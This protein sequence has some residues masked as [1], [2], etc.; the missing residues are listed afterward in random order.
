MNRID[1]IG[2]VTVAVLALALGLAPASLAARDRSSEQTIQDSLGTGIPACNAAGQPSSSAS[3]I[4]GA[5]TYDSR[6]LPWIGQTI[7]MSVVI[8]TTN[9][10]CLQD[11]EGTTVATAQRFGVE[12]VLPRGAKLRT[13]TDTA[14]TCR[15]GPRSTLCPQAVSVR[16]G[17]RG[18]VQLA[19]DGAAD[20]RFLIGP[21]TQVRL[22]FRVRLTRAFNGVGKRPPRCGRR[23]APCSR[24]ALKNF[25]AIVVDNDERAAEPAAHSTVSPLLPLLAL[26]LVRLPTRSI[27]AAR[28]RRGMTLRL[29]HLPRKAKVRARLR[30]GRTTIARQVATTGASGGK[31]K[32]RLR[33]VASRRGLIRLGARLKLRLTL[34]AP[35]VIRQAATSVIR[36]R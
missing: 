34:A 24:A 12:V 16:P 17:N 36:V 19:Y 9:T 28:A 21:F 13:A 14:V 31:A 10:T 8:G 2:G 3:Q 1:P 6:A 27:S 20:G 30:R 23:R 33:P 7:P 26:R 18:G 15:F 32:L 25:A 5:V 4:T 35:G 11:R 22:S 29:V